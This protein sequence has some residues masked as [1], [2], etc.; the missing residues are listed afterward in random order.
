MTSWAVMYAPVRTCRRFAYIPVPKLCG[1]QRSRL[2]L[3]AESKA[4]IAG[5]PCNAMEPMVRHSFQK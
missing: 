4:V 3:G 2:L 5:V 1:G